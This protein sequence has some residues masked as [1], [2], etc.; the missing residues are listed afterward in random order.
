MSYGLRGCCR[1][2]RDTTDKA[3]SSEVNRTDHY[4][5]GGREAQGSQ[6]CQ[7]I[8]LFLRLS[9]IRPQCAIYFCLQRSSLLENTAEPQRQ[10]RIKL[11]SNFGKK[12]YV[13]ENRGSRLRHQLISRQV[14]PGRI[15]SD[16]DSRGL[17]SPDH[18]RIHVS[19]EVSSKQGYPYVYMLQ[20]W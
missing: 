7:V 11:T 20:G 16:R 12:L 1:R 3:C 14:W 13:R 8:L 9:R 18:E 6:L 2:L 17:F 15:S 4:L 5:A 10:F 19:V